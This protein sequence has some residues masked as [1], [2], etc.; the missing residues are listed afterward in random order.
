MEGY[1]GL[2]YEAL[3]AAMLCHPV[4]GLATKHVGPL[5]KPLFKK[6]KPINSDLQ[7]AADLSLL[8]AVVEV[9]EVCIE[10]LKGSGLKSARDDIKWLK[11]K[12]RT[13]IRK[14]NKIKK[15]DV[16]QGPLER[17]V[18]LRVLV[19]PDADAAVEIVSP[20][21]QRLVELSFGGG[22]CPACYESKVR[23]S[24]FPLTSRNFVEHIKQ[25]QRARDVFQTYLLADLG[26]TLDTLAAKVGRL[27]VIEKEVGETKIIA[28]ET[29]TTVDRIADH[30][31]PI[32]RPPASVLKLMPLTKIEEYL[33]QSGRLTI[34]GN[35][36]V[37]RDAKTEKCSASRSKNLIVIGPPACGKT[38]YAIEYIKGVVGSVQEGWIVAVLKFRDPSEIEWEAIEKD[39]SLVMEQNP[40]GGVLFLDDLSQ[41][42]QG[43][44]DR[45]PIWFKRR[46]K[47]RRGKRAPQRLDFRPSK[48][49]AGDLS[50]REK[51]E[52]LV[53]AFLDLPLGDKFVVATMSSEY[54][55]PLLEKPADIAAVADSR[56]VRLVR[57]DKERAGA[58]LR[59]MRTGF[60]NKAG[61]IERFSVAISEE[62]VDEFARRY[63]NKDIDPEAVA[64]FV[65]DLVN[66]GKERIEFGDLD[67]FAPT[68]VSAWLQRRW[69]VIQEFG[70][71]AWACFA[72]I[73]LLGREVEGPGGLNRVTVGI[74]KTFTESFGP[75][76]TKKL[77]GDAEH[78]EQAVRILEE[79][80]HVE[81]TATGLRPRMDL[82]LHEQ[83]VEDID[84][85]IPDLE[86]FV[87]QLSRMKTSR[88]SARGL[89]MGQA[90]AR[91][92]GIR[93]S[94]D[95]AEK[96]ENEIARLFAVL[97]AVRMRD[98]GFQ[99]AKDFASR[100]S[101][102][103]RVYARTCFDLGNRYY[104]RSD[105]RFAEV[106]YQAAV[107]IGPDFPDAWF[108]LG[109]MIYN[110]ADDSPDPR[111]RYF[112]SA[113]MYRRAGELD[114]RNAV[115]YNNWGDV[116]FRLG[117]YYADRLERAT[118]D[119]EY[120]KYLRDREFKRAIKLFVGAIRLNPRYLKAHYNRGLAYACLEHYARAIIEFDEVIELNPDF[121]EA[122]HTRGLAYDYW[123]DVDEA[124]L[125]EERLRKA[126]DDYREALSRKP[127]LAECKYHLA[128]ALARLAE[129]TGYPS[130]LSDEVET[131]YKGL[132]SG[133]PIEGVA[134]SSIYAS[135]GDFHTGRVSRS[136][137]PKDA[138]LEAA[139][140]YEKAAQLDVAA[141]RFLM[142]QRGALDQAAR[143]MEGTQRQE[144]FRKAAGCCKR[145]VELNPEEET[146]WST[147]GYQL[148]CLASDYTSGLVDREEN[149]RLAL[150]WGEKASR[151]I[152]E[153]LEA[154]SDFAVILQN[155]F[156]LLSDPLDCLKKARGLYDSLASSEGGLI[157]G[158][159]T[160]FASLVLECAEVC[161]SL[162]ERR[163]DLERAAGLLDEAR[164]AEDSDPWTYEGLGRAER[165][166]ADL[167][168]GSR[169]ILH[170][171]RS[172]EYYAKAAE[173]HRDRFNRA[174]A[175]GRSLVS[176]YLAKGDDELLARAES[177]FEAVGGENNGWI[178]EDLSRIKVLSGDREMG[179][180]ILERAMKEKWVYPD[181]ARQDRI[182]RE[183]L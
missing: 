133:S 30:V 173:R 55:R 42:L 132:T 67:D 48:A 106:M 72:L 131:L 156:N 150:S 15:S 146:L 119:V 140:K 86:W 172:A 7:R 154:K 43:T 147:Y 28:Q 32:G 60:Y 151:A 152:P 112:E 180:A 12:R 137:A 77:G 25:N 27:G 113:A 145:A 120:I 142:S 159:K 90:D 40:K 170:Y 92:D 9:C 108:N 29:K 128:V 65:L 37:A 53:Q 26:M 118:E 3:L 117:G 91:E 68:A 99:A 1:V 20:V 135:W 56:V 16:A 166:M 73:R 36:Y 107:S 63:G 168:T 6:T 177:Q 103:L 100:S 64:I 165:L 121:A 104:E 41:Y 50:P 149:A 155:V 143:H 71:A 97:I 127:D 134:P 45:T 179:V 157:R 39:Y 98:R 62:V 31:V 75:L 96:V 8:E 23:E 14:R 5:L 57:F 33:L 54:A 83:P 176:R 94:D 24:I 181:A 129:L 95:A 93:F 21:N 13:E 148:S 76:L 102:D 17:V 111:R 178:L 38:R 144:T 109:L 138:Y 52:K 89:E 114:P 136:A 44:E 126:I 87:T 161:D 130:S 11:S 167:A 82:V 123:A 160:N 10:D 139:G 59:G 61:R 49:S 34:I 80:R 183:L 66:K 153:D 116:H 124:D 141:W 115:I 85:L 110:R 47:V 125:S 122:Y 105:M 35:E 158:E 175:A 182:L 69:P 19:A 84:D 162:S 46:Q 74:D 171:E 164:T 101:R 70:P 169:S 174:V 18:D 4:Y 163:A 88:P 78:Y 79:H 51:L 22:K 81:I 58:L 2:G